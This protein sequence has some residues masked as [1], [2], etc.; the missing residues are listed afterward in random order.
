MS[1]L[2]LTKM[3]LFVS[4]I[5]KD[6]FLGGAFSDRLTSHHVSIQV[7]SFLRIHIFQ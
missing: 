7:A 2:T 1:L 6:F 5:V 4:F 3:N